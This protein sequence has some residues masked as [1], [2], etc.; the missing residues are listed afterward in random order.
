MHDGSVHGWDDA[1]LADIGLQDLL[2]DN[3][4][5]IG[6]DFFCFL[7]VCVSNC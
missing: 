5:K 4:R 3:R 2:V 6:T 1:F 7:F